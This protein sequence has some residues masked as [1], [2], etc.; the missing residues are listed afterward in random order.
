MSWGAG[1]PG[2]GRARGAARTARAMLVS[3]LLIAQSSMLTGGCG[4]RPLGTEALPADVHSVAVGPIGNST[5]QAGLQG[6]LADYLTE[7]LR[8]D[9]RVRVIPS[10]DADAVIE[11][12]IV[13]YGNEGVAWDTQGVA[14][15]FRVQVVASMILRDR[16][17]Q[18]S[19]ISDGLVGEAYYTV[20][21]G[22]GTTLAAQDEATRRALRDLA[23]RVATRIIEGL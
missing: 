19:L 3:S 14:R 1:G 2:G 15:R 11:T 23:D 12:I 5:F 20:G 21:T 6:F 7:R 17:S 18:R 13:G 10:P 9:G 8:A 16:R 22:I 4:Y